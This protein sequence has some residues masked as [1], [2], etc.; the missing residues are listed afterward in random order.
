MLTRA[1]PDS[2]KLAA[3]G[4]RRPCAS[5]RRPF[6]LQSRVMAAWAP[7]CTAIEPP[8]GTARILDLALSVGGPRSDR[9]GDG[10]RDQTGRR[11]ASATHP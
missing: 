8:G 7:Q 5:T 4:S 10:R 9:D 2:G 6:G 11:C 1:V 3:Y